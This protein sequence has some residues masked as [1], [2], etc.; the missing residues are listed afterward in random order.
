MRRLLAAAAL[1]AIACGLAVL[2]AAAQSDG[3]DPDTPIVI[4]AEEIIFVFG[5]RTF[6]LPTD[7]PIGFPGL[8][9][10]LPDR[11]QS[12]NP[13]TGEVETDIEAFEAAY[14]E[15][16][17]AF[18]FDQSMTGSEFVGPCGGFAFSFDD[19]EKL[20]DFAF[21]AG[22]ADPP[23]DMNGEVAFSKANPFLVHAA[24]TVFYFGFTEQPFFNHMW[25][26]GLQG[27][28]LDEGGD[29]NPRGK[30]R[31][32]GILELDEQIPSAVRFTGLF[33]F[34]GKIDAGATPEAKTGLHCEG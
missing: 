2:P 29:P 14:D 10:K 30:D 21:D 18:P 19:S 1:A 25:D 7:E 6:S 16:Q 31:N 3:P 26:L 27:I 8:W 24:G 32:A 22:D 33:K 20:I 12:M 5:G 13:D 15:F 28:A 17:T 4:G 23:T 11:F 9:D 34:G